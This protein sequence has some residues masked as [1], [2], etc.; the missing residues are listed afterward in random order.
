MFLKGLFNL[1]FKD[2][3]YDKYS[4]KGFHRFKSSW[5]VLEEK[6]NLPIAVNT[7]KDLPKS[8]ITNGI[9]A[10][11]NTIRETDPPLTDIQTDT[12]FKLEVNPNITLDEIKTSMCQ[13]VNASI[14]DYDT[15]HFEF[16]CDIQDSQENYATFGFS[17]NTVYLQS[18]ETLVDS[19]YYSYRVYEYIFEED[20]TGSFIDYDTKETVEYTYPTPG[21]Y[22]YLMWDDGKTSYIKEFPQKEE[23]IFYPFEETKVKISSMA[24]Y[25]Q[26][27]SGEGTNVSILNFAGFSF[28]V[29]DNYTDYPY[30]FYKFNGQQWVY[31]T[32]LNGMTFTNK[33]I[34]DQLT[35][36]DL[37]NIDLNAEVRHNHLNKSVLDQ[38]TEEHLEPKQLVEGIFYE[39]ENLKGLSANKNSV[40]TAE[41][42]WIEGNAAIILPVYEVISSAALNVVTSSSGKTTTTT[43]SIDA[44]CTD[45]ENA[46]F[47]INKISSGHQN[48]L[49]EYPYGAIVFADEPDETYYIRFSYSGNTITDNVIKLQFT[50]I[51]NQKQFP[52]TGNINRSI[53]SISLYAANGIASHAEGYDTIAGGDY[54]HAEG[55]G[56]RTFYNSSSVRGRYN[57]IDYDVGYLDVVGNGY[58]EDSRSNAYTLDK[59]GNAWFA[60]GI[61]SDIGI[62]VPSIAGDTINASEL[63]TTNSTT[64]DFTATNAEIETLNVSSN[65]TANV[66]YPEQVRANGL[67]RSETQITSPWISTTT[68]DLNMPYIEHREFPST[69]LCKLTAEETTNSTS[70]DDLGFD[71]ELGKWYR[72]A[73][74]T[75]TYILQCTY[76]DSNHETLCLGDPYGH[77]FTIRRNAT[78]DSDKSF[79]LSTENQGHEFTVEVFHNGQMALSGYLASLHQKIIDLETKL[80]ALES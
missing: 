67:I 8:F 26:D 49:P 12:Y 62:D 19:T 69:Q 75:G 64:T 7:Y 58:G 18:L 52:V 80:A 37:G 48:I 30:G 54:S 42:A 63:T 35:E 73:L 33:E 13:L 29:S 34:L 78:A 39:D 25:P 72:V 1:G 45:A 77:G 56:T 66:I 47:I 16:Y 71:I 21:W 36:E 60:G 68:F 6:M 59:E 70:Y 38:L 55:Y 41:Q 10:V 61:S 74:Y 32:S 9:S 46:Q 31:E 2:N 23:E 24:Y 5:N 43:V 11:L 3:S 15:T 44:T 40:P 79:N 27:A 51:D 28:I 20:T 14:D 57:L 17:K 53:Q 4:N 22:S 76:T 65:L 50:Q